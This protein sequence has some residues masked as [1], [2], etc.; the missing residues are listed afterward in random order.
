MCSLFTEA[1]RNHSA[2]SSEIDIEYG[3]VISERTEMA[4][5]VTIFAKASDIVIL[6]D[7][8]D[9]SYR[10]VTSGLTFHNQYLENFRSDWYNSINPPPHTHTHTH[11][12]V[13]ENSPMR[14]LRHLPVF[15]SLN[16]DFGPELTVHSETY[17]RI[18]FS[19]KRVFF[20]CET[21]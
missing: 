17:R 19:W 12:T 6:G 18:T 4:I 10:N 2:I 16:V 3:I 15:I 9:N 1:Y 11:C 7:L 13:I 21:I 14:V 20:C 5:V 8:N